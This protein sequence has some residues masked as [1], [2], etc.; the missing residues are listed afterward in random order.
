MIRSRST[1]F[2]NTSL[3]CL[4]TEALFAE[5]GFF[6]GFSHERNLTHNGF[7]G[8]ALLSYFR[9][10]ELC[11]ETGRSLLAAGIRFSYWRYAVFFRL[12]GKGGAWK[13]LRY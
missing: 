11:S 3:S 8:M 12:G 1:T 13:T 4:S 2:D 6:M 10:R 5:S 9:V 7:R